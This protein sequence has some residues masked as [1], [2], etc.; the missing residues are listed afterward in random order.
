MGKKQASKARKKAL[1]RVEKVW[2]NDKIAF[3][4]AVVT[5]II[6]ILHR[7]LFKPDV[8][9]GEQG[10]RTVFLFS[11]LRIILG[12]AAEVSFGVALGR[13]ML[14]QHSVPLVAA[15]DTAE[16][17]YSSGKKKKKQKKHGKAGKVVGFVLTY[18]FVFLM[19]MSFGVRET[20]LY[21]QRNIRKLPRFDNLSYVCF[22]GETLMDMC[23]GET[24]TVKVSGCRISTDSFSY[25]TRTRRFNRRK[26]GSLTYRFSVL[27]DDGNDRIAQVSDKE[28]KKLE[29]RLDPE[30]EYTIKLYKH[31]GLIASVEEG[32]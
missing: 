16:E 6:S 8:M 19:Y 3:I 12:L 29:S 10:L 5:F 4:A 11:L 14:I 22:A 1:D 2:R 17:K 24:V 25:S 20:A 9:T 26:H 27:M 31:S 15:A 28:A 23:Q 7:V 13:I 18:A 21:S 30:K 32:E